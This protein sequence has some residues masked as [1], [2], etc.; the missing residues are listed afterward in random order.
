[1]HY[2]EQAAKAN[3]G[4][5]PGGGANGAPPGF[6]FHPYPPPEQITPAAVNDFRARFHRPLTAP[7]PFRAGANAAGGSPGAVAAIPPGLPPM[8]Q[9]ALA[10]AQSHAGVAVAVEG[11]GAP[12]GGAID[13]TL[14]GGERTTNGNGAQSSTASASASLDADGDGEGDGDG[15][16][17]GEDGSGSDLDAEVSMGDERD[18]HEVAQGL[19]DKS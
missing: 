10:A 13:P 9:Q 12:A 3:G 11:A 2:A 15:D 17:D 5:P 1:M 14:S 8:I 7:S 4:E 16:G 6:A 18:E 19:N